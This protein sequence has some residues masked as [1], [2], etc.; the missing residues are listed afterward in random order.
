MTISLPE[1][2]TGMEY[3]DFVAATLRALGYF[4]ETRVVLREEK[5]EVLEL[6]VVATPLACPSKDRELYEAK[7]GGVSFSNL[8]KLYG[9]RV[10]L[11]VKAA[12]LASLESSDPTHKAVYESKGAELGVRVCCHPV[13]YDRLD[14][15]ASPQNA[16][17]SD[18]RKATVVAAWYLQ[19]AKRLAQAAHSQQCKAHKGDALHEQL[20]RYGFDVQA[21]FF[22]KTPLQRAESL[23][24]AY[25]D[26]PKLSGDVVSLLAKERAVEAR[27][28]WN[29]VNDTHKH[30]WLQHQIL[31]EAT[32]RI[33]I[34]KHALDHV[35]DTGGARVPTFALKIGSQAYNVQA[36]NLPPRFVEGLVTLH[37]HPHSLRLP[38]LFQSF[39]EL[40]GGFIFPGSGDELAFVQ[41]LTGVPQAEILPAIRLLDEFFAPPGGSLFYEVKSEMLC[42]KMVPGFVRGIGSFLRQDLF[43]LKEYSDKYSGHGWLLAKWHNAAYYALEQEL[44]A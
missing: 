12:C 22:A 19:I 3:E 4:V 35:V 36:H 28:I 32:A 16:L 13:D 21:S 7:K 39:V 25:F 1:K 9:Q 38:Y 10:Y 34:I 24:A 8:F 40:L 11:G 27:M 37:S 23:Y 41:A 20:R 33:A 15:L 31:T 2:P 17:G 26:H 30:L 44:E 5:K 29:E 43:A 42:L 14:T 18:Q 6:D